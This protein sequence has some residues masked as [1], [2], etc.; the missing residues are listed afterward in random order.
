MRTIT[1]VSSSSTMSVTVLNRRCTS[2]PD[3]ENH[4][5]KS[6]WE[7]ISN[8]RADGYLKH[9]VSRWTFWDG[10]YEPV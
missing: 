6:E 2:F 7:F 3:S 5:E 8:N 4:R 9:S 1:N 10:A